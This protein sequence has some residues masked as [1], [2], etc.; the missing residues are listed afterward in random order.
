MLDFFGKNRKKT[1]ENERLELKSGQMDGSDDDYPFSKKGDFFVGA[2]GVRENSGVAP[3]QLGSCFATGS[4]R[5]FGQLPWSGEEAS[6][7]SR[8]DRGRLELICSIE[9]ARTR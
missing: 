6:K 1:L 2:P 3:H 9:I 8:K 5:G 7:K 4:I